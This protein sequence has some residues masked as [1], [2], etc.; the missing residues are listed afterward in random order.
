MNLHT[1]GTRLAASAAVGAAAAVGLVPLAD[2][3]LAGMTGWIVVSVTFSLWTWL[4][5]R[6]LDGAE[7]RGHATRE[8]PTHAVS[9]AVLVLA[10]LASLVGVGVLLVAGS[11]AGGTLPWEALTGAASVVASWVVVHV[12]Y[13]L[14]YARLFYAADIDAAIDFGGDRDPDYHDF[15]YLAFTIGMTYQVSDTTVAGAE[16]RRAVL[17]H[18]MLSYLLGAV[19]LAVTLNLV[20]QLSSSV[21]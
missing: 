19:V 15:A 7:T 3:W 8:D 20:V 13:M 10:S 5:V 17:R 4:I 16:L 1:A 6:R 11:G 14:H 12:L 21:G 2:P 9:R 18:A